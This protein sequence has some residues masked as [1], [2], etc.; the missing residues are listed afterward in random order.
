MLREFISIAFD[1]VT[2]FASNCWPDIAAYRRSPAARLELSG[3]G[4]RCV[5]AKPSVAANQ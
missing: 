5:S 2:T 4:L 3:E 1:V